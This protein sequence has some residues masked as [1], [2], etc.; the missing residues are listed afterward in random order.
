M[1]VA[2]GPRACEIWRTVQ[3]GKILM[4]ISGRG[5]PPLGN[6]DTSGHLLVMA[7]CPGGEIDEPAGLVVLADGLDEKVAQDFASRLDRNPS[8]LINFDYLDTSETEAPGAVWMF[9]AVEMQ[10]Q[11]VAEA[12]ARQVVLVMPDDHPAIEQEGFRA[13]MLAYELACGE[14]GAPDLPLSDFDYFDLR[15]KV[16]A[17][18]AVDPIDRAGMGELAV[19]ISSAAREP[20]KDERLDVLSADIEDAL[21]GRVEIADRLYSV[22]IDTNLWFR[23]NGALHKGDGGYR[24]IV[25]AHGL[26]ISQ[27][28]WVRA[29]VSQSPREFLMQSRMVPDMIGGEEILDTRIVADPSV[30]W[31]GVDLSGVRD[32]ERYAQL[33]EISREM[34]AFGR[35]LTLAEVAARMLEMDAEA[36]QAATRA[37]GAG[38]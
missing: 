22:V 2:I 16:L 21:M 5:F 38:R 29:L 18:R 9:L 28:S 17:L 13:L 37:L 30:G 31:V 24:S 3:F 23:V 15:R 25:V 11:W 35:K 7:L 32:A 19:M 20:V 36:A 12:F 1:L 6:L 4:D 26:T 34:A 33:V 27:A 8:I 14:A 10:S